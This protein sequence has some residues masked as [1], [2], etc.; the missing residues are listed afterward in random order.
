MTTLTEMYAHLVTSDHAYYFDKAISVGILS[1]E[2]DESNYA[3]HYMFMH[4][5][6]DTKLT[7][8]KDIMSR[9]YLVC[10]V[11]TGEILKS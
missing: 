9:E 4:H 6:L 5:D 2:K 11:D 10:N 3:G 1:T 7:H 8:F